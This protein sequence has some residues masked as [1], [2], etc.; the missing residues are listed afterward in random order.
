MRIEYVAARWK[1]GGL[2]RVGLYLAE[3]LGWAELD[4]FVSR[5]IFWLIQISTLRRKGYG[6]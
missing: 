1:D 5:L 3:E 2:N 6:S 4:F